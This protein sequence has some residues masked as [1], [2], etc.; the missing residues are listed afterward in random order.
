MDKH[1][2]GLHP[3]LRRVWVPQEEQPIA[4]LRQ[5]YQWM[6]LYG[7]VGPESG[8]TYWWI[9]PH[10]NTKIFNQVL[11]DFATE[12]YLEKNKRVL[13]IMD[14]AGWHTSHSLN[15]HEGLD[16]IYLPKN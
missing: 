8:E 11:D 14:Q 7:F 12:Y 6:W 13:L 10:V 3:V 4:D 2:L 16:L 15:R 9:L 1:R 5:K